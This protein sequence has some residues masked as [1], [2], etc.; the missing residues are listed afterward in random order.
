M[1][2]RS[3]GRLGR[4]GRAG[5]GQVQG[6]EYLLEHAGGRAVSA[7]DRTAGPP[8]AEGNLQFMLVSVPAERAV[9]R[10]QPLRL[11][12]GRHRPGRHRRGRRPA[13]AAPPGPGAARRDEAHCL[14][15]ADE[16]G[17]AV[18]VRAGHAQVDRVDVI[19]DTGPRVLIQPVDRPARRNLERVPRVDH[20]PRGRPGRSGR[21]ARRGRHRGKRGDG[22]RTPEYQPAHDSGCDRAT[23]LPPCFAERRRTSLSIRFRTR[24]PDNPVGI[25]EEKANSVYAALTIYGHR[26]LTPVTA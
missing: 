12:A 10:G 17:G 22:R 1:R 11:D 8:R 14:G 3:L 23:H 2:G 4:L 26:G 15:P 13:A 7:K 5:R 6:A 16:P 21:P 19:A 24:N 18:H 9:H 20:G 25:R